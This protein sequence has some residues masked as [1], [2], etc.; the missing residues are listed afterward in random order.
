[1][2]W[3]K[4]GVIMFDWIIEQGTV[5]D[6]SGKDGVVC[7]VGIR[8]GQI[9]AVGTLS[10]AEGRRIDA[11]GKTVTPG[12]VDIH[13]HGDLAMFR[14]GF[15]ELELRQGL[16]T[17]INGNCGMSAAPFGAAYRT[18]IMEYLAPVIGPSEQAPSECMADYLQAVSA[19]SLP[20]NVGMLVGGGVL[21]SDIC[22]HESRELTNEEYRLLHRHLEQALADGALGVSLGLGY[23][24]ECFYSTEGLIRA[25]APLS[26]GKI[27]FT[28]H[29]RDEGT[30]VDKSVAEMLTVAKALRCPVEISHLKAI[31]IQNWGVKIPN[32]LEMLDRA[33]QDG[34]EVRWDVY[35][36]TAG[37]TQL[38]HILP[39]EVLAGGTDETCFRLRD[40]VER[41]TIKARLRTGEDYNNISLLVGWENIEV[42]TVTLPEH[43]SFVGLSIPEAA[44]HVGKSPEDFTLDLLADERCAVTMIDRITAEEDIRT[45][46]RTE[47]VSVISDATYPTEGLPHPRLYGNF[48]RLIEKYVV[49]E[50]VLTLPQAVKKMTRNPA[51]ALRLHQK[52]RIEVGADADLNIF[53]P[54]QLH[55]TGTFA[56]PAHHPVGIETVF[57]NGE[58]QILNGVLC[59]ESH[60]A[61]LR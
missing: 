30:N 6:G 10:Q 58:P 5:M 13:R 16:T 60:G 35:P 27:P 22:G 34:V 38:L 46:L 57:V 54:E 1:M 11:R 2:I 49:Q 25:L 3:A 19:Q 8:N 42:S 17:I 18:E 9:A 36:Y 50:H 41:E 33:R 29:T 51:E 39:P 28:V 24:P 4:E 45:I 20:I 14:P 31:G 44:A 53:I 37:S 52:G 32:V 26:G 15:G 56:D 47:P 59:K 55:E 43:R 23:A 21:R 48:V 7:D 61:V 40:P 12:F